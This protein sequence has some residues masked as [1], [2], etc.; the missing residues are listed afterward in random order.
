MSQDETHAGDELVEGRA[1]DGRPIVAAK[2]GIVFVEELLRRCTD[3]GI[4]LWKRLIGAPF[5]PAP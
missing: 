4:V 2:A 3:L 5:L 1:G